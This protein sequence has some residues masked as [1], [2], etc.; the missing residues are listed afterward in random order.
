MQTPFDEFTF[1]LHARIVSIAVNTEALPI[2][3]WESLLYKPGYIDGVSC[4]TL[5]PIG[6]ACRS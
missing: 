1:R 3:P 5:L 4:A 6:V 2:L